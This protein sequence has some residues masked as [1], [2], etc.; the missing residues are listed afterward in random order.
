LVVANEKGRILFG[1]S[2]PGGRGAVRAFAEWVVN[3][4]D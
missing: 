1:K 2:R 3:G 4:A